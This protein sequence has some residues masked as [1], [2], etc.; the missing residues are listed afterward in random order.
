MW[1]FSRKNPVEKIVYKQRAF[2][3][4]QMNNLLSRWTQQS[5]EIDKD[6]KEGGAALRSRAREAAK[7]N[8]YAKKYLDILRTN[9]VGE[10]GIRLQCKAVNAN[11]TPDAVA[12]EKIESAWQDFSRSYNC[13]FSGRMSLIDMQSLFIATLAR[14]GECLIRMH[15]NAATDHKLRLQFLDVGLLDEQHNENLKNGRYVKMGIEYDKQ[16]NVIAFHLTDSAKYRKTRER[17]P[18][19]DIIHVFRQEYPDQHRGFSWMSAALVELHHLGAFMEAA[20]IASRIGASSMGFFTKSMGADFVGD[21]KTDNN[22]IIMDLEPGTFR[23]LPDNVD[24]KSFDSK[25]P[26]DMVDGFVKR[27]LKS[28]A[29]GLNV[30]Y[31]SLAADPESTSYGTLRQFAIED[32]DYFRT[33]QRL[34]IEQFLEPIYFA[35]LRQNIGRLLKP[36]RYEKMSKV[37]W[38]PRGWLWIDPT[39]DAVGV[40]KRLAAGLTAPSIVAAEMGLDFNEVCQQA[41]ADR[42]TMEKYKL[43]PIATEAQ[44]A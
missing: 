17:V 6:I 23:S 41:A 36:E 20:I 24:F 16:G 33:L 1:P 26:S 19:N 13:S 29:A 3:A 2:A 25:Y 37:R 22:E 35:W 44:N 32:R 14:D 5:T 10:N 31:N 15:N 30:N 18:A 42:A 7:N 11:G 43:L 8:D 4:A 12:N 9:V 21:G 38:Q 34:L 39:K 28:I 27:S 40:E